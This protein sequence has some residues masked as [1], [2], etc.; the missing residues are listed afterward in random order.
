M[1][2]EASKNG[3][4]LITHSRQNAD[5]SITE[6]TTKLTN[7]K[8][9]EIFKQSDL[10]EN[11]KL[12]TKEELAKFEELKAEQEKTV[13]NL[14]SLSQ[15]LSETEIGNSLEIPKEIKKNPTTTDETTIKLFKQLCSLV[16]NFL[17]GLAE[18]FGIKTDDSKTE[19]PKEM[20]K[21]VEPTQAPKPVAPTQA[22]KPVEP[23]QAP[24][25]VAPTQA[26]KPVEPTQA[27]KPVAPTQAPKP[28]EPTQAPK[29]VAPTQAPKPVEPTQAPKPVA[30]TQAPKPVEPIQVPK[31]QIQKATVPY[32]KRRDFDI[33]EVH[34]GQI[35]DC[36]FLSALSKFPEWIKDS[37]CL[38]WNNDGS[39]EVF[40]YDNNNNR[41]AYHISKSELENETVDYN[42]DYII[43]PKQDLT[44]KALELGLIKSGSA[45]HFSLGRTVEVL[46]GKNNPKTNNIYACMSSYTPNDVE[47]GVTASLKNVG[48][49]TYNVAGQA[50]EGEHS[51]KINGINRK[52]NIVSVSNPWSDDL[53]SE[54]D[55][56]KIPFSEFVKYFKIQIY[57]EENLNKNDMMAKGYSKYVG[58]DYYETYS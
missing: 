57:S 34:Q 14:N 6:E 51:Y 42:N 31:S 56:I 13:S 46:Y 7:S 52:T 12:D 48:K 40:L 20:P 23:T 18:L 37:G 41:R 5:G 43:N 9:I 32:T 30:P 35:G 44:L 11:Q 53:N 19:T 39:A 49:G 38:R 17:K 27:P 55:D 29:P 15:A 2:V 47:K 10:N 26:P 1:G 25:P 36:T 54:K 58:N 24:K 8:V 3:Y 45:E 33:T 16:Q 28:V 21:P 50:I 22:P 4:I